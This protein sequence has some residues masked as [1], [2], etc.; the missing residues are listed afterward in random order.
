MIF[1]AIGFTVVVDPLLVDVEVDPEPDDVVAL[2]EVDVDVEVDDVDG[3]RVDLLLP[4]VEVVVGLPDVVG[5]LPRVAGGF[6][7]ADAAENV[8]HA[9]AAT[10][11]IGAENRIR[12]PPGDSSGARPMPPRPYLFRPDWRCV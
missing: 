5:L 11:I 8:R 1:A 4:W 2:S 3:V 6:E 12:I 7:S 10:A 9:A